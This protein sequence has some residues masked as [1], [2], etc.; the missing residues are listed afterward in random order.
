MKKFYRISMNQNTSPMMLLWSIVIALYGM[1]F[2]NGFIGS[3]GGIP[4]FAG[5]FCVIYFLKSMMNR[6]ECLSHQLAMTGKD[7]IYHLF[8]HYF[9]GYVIVWG[10]VRILTVIARI[11]GWG[12]IEG[13]SV[14]S[15]FHNLFTTNMTER[16]A[17]IFSAILM[18]AFAMSFFPIIIIRR[19]KIIAV[20]LLADSAI[21]VGICY[22]IRLL[23]RLF[24]RDDLEKRSK[25]VLD[26]LL[27]AKVPQ[28]WETIVY[29]IFVVGLFLLVSLM[30]IKIGARLHGPKAGSLKLDERQFPV[31]EGTQE[32]FDEAYELLV[33]KKNFMQMI[34]SIVGAVLIVIALLYMFLPHKHPIGYTKVAEYLTEDTMFGPMVYGNEIYVPITEELD[35]H[36]TGKP[37]GYLGYQGQN[38]D[39]RFYR[40]AVSNMLYR[41]T[42]TTKLKLY[43]VSQEGN[44]EL[45]SNYF[46]QDLYDERNTF[47]LWDEEWESES[48]SQ[49]GTSGYA[50]LDG[51]VVR[52]LRLEFSDVQLRVDDFEEYDAY[53]TIIA[54]PDVSEPL[55][56]ENFGGIWM[57]CIFARENEFYFCN[58]DNLIQGELRQRLLDCIG[59]NT[60][61]GNPIEPSEIIE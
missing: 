9:C 20:Y 16:W 5:F 41:Q 18:F 43:G 47:F 7:E 12:M 27:L 34:Y 37:I 2:I 24:I 32:D 55:Q 39:S 36:K 11:T 48:V 44:F 53:F 28:L 4:A 50:I 30:V 57:G 42:G 6:G 46:K 22:G 54:Y 23:T 35:Y 25:C 56:K 21:F 58:Y 1:L 59:G 14:Y 45:A 13:I 33:R 26:D 10:I 17:Y 19:K 52:D 29:L 31:F 15:Y 3:L 60:N 51:D 61:G 40:L 38:C 8:F 49:K